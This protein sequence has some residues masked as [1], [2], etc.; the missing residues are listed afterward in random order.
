L[1]AARPVHRHADACREAA[2][3]ADELDV[4]AHCALEELGVGDGRERK[5]DRMLARCGALA[6]VRHRRPLLGRPPLRI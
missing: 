2:L 6:L 3:A 4:L 5:G 1:S